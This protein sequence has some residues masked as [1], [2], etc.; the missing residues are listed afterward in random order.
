MLAPLATANAPMHGRISAVRPDLRRKERL[1]A[2]I[3]NAS[4]PSRHV[5][6]NACSMGT[7]LSSD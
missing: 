1:I 6:T 4:R 3:R 5:M 2:T 7:G